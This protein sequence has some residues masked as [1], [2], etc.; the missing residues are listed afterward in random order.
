VLLFAVNTQ[1]LTQALVFGGCGAIH[2]SSLDTQ[3]GDAGESKADLLLRIQQL[4]EKNERLVF[5]PWS[6]YF[7]M[8]TVTPLQTVSATLPIGA[9]LMSQQKNFE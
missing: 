9:H 7:E 3:D 1:R 8:C 5:L 4:M 2:A 6:Y